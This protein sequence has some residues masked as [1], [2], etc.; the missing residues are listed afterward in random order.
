MTKSEL[1]EK[2]AKRQGHLPYQAIE[3]TVKK[4]IEYMAQSLT[5]GQRIEIRGFGSFSLH[6]RLPRIGR[7]P[8]TGV[9]VELSGKYVPHFKPGKEL[10][11]R[12][13][14]SL[15][16]GKPIKASDDAE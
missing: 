6:Y 7:N 15:L 16:E 2:L 4:I 14:Q 11:E 10:R 13:N 9:T 8:K 1:I 12:V 3:D 5:V